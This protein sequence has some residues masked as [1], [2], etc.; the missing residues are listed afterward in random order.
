MDNGYMSPLIQKMIEALRQSSVALPKELIFKAASENTDNLDILFNIAIDCAQNNRLEQ[1]VGILNELA[2]LRKDDPGIFY[3]LGF[4]ASLKHEHEKA[5]E[6]YD[7]AIGLNPQDQAALINKGASLNELKRHEEALTALD[8]AIALNPATPQ[9]WSNKGTALNELKRYKEALSHYEKAIGLDPSYGEAWLNMGVTYAELK[10]HEEALTH[11]NK[12]LEINPNDIE[13]WSNKGT[14]LN[15]LKRY[16][17]AAQSFQKVITLNPQFPFGKGV[18]LHAKLHACDWAGI[19]DLYSSICQ[20]IS[21]N[22]KSAD[23]FGFQGIC[24]DEAILKKC[25]EIFSL[26]KFPPQEKL[27]P[28]QASKNHPKIRIGYL[29]GEFREQATAILMTELWE[30]HNKNRFE[31]YAFDNG[32]DDKS[33][34]RKRIEDAFDGLID[35]SRMSDTQAA[36]AI[37]DKEIDI[38]VNL[39]GFFGRPRQGIFARKPAPIQ[40]NYLG[41]PGTIGAD[42]IDYLI[43]D[44]T[45]IPDESRR[46]YSEKIV[47]LPHCYQTND[48]KRLISDRQFSREELGLP[49][50]GFVFCC[51]NNSYKI[52]PQTFDSWMK[53]LH[54]VKGSV[55]WLIEDN[56]E[57]NQNLKNEA[58]ARGIDPA[59]IIFAKRLPLPEH[60]ARHRC[61]DLFLD[62]LPYNAH[63]TASDALWAGLPVITLTGSSFPGRV[64][65]SLLKSIDLPQLITSSSAT[66]EALAVELAN[67]PEKLGQIKQ[68]LNQN[69]LTTPLFDVPLLTKNIEAA[70]I[71][72]YQRNLAGLAPEHIDLKS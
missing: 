40:V 32:W 66:Y 56:L 37:L 47:R 59:R 71:A 60:L 63:T 58:T 11:Y 20:D 1:S 38:L 31:I 9:A 18:F 25:A 21:E 15:E 33:P 41:F 19:D 3:S 48:S 34:R 52:L 14:A 68:Q 22:K 70:Y 13:A 49:K 69:R 65:T 4:M 16:G 61:A 57:A 2:L 42:Y 43:A 45:V 23:P 17:A 55:L 8:K 10:R 29:C 6:F 51:F 62:T 64:A 27:H 35:I 28:A 72:M 46:Y 24:D 54:A 67:N 30:L 53:I 7:K 44:S 39:N 50:E 36:K 26:A 5:L 12:A